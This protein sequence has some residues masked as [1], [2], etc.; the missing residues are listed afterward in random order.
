[1]TKDRMHSLYSLHT[2]TYIHTHTYK[3]VHKQTHSRAAHTQWQLTKWRIDGYVALCVRAHVCECRCVYSWLTGWMTVLYYVYIALLWR[4]SN[5]TRQRRRRRHD[6][7]VAILCHGV[8]CM[9]VHTAVHCAQLLLLLPLFF[10]L[11]VET[12]K[13]YIVKS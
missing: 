5:T 1:M 2:H 9:Y 7:N 3:R 8:S 10:M 11:S 4:Q 12:M 13:L 6:I